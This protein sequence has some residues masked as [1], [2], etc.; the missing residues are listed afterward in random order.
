MLES[1]QTRETAVRVKPTG[2]EATETVR[3]VAPIRDTSTRALRV[4]SAL[5]NPFD[6]LKGIFS[7]IASSVFEVRLLIDPFAET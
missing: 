5:N 3:T 7:V 2:P 4:T 1:S 6:V